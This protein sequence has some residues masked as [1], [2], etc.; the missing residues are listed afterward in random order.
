[1]RLPPIKTII[2]MLEH[3]YTAQGIADDYG[4][5]VRAVHQKLNRAGIDTADIAHSHKRE[6]LP[7]DETILHL[8]RQGKTNAEIARVYGCSRQ[9]VSV[10]V[11]KILRTK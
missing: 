1:M 8:I 11:R 9:A 7:D 4:V 10:I 2:K 5:R 3:G 6:K